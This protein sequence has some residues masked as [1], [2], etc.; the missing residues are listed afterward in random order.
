MVAS[1]DESGVFSEPAFSY[2][3][4]TAVYTAGEQQTGKNPDARSDIYSLGITLYQLTTGRLPEKKHEDEVFNCKKE[5]SVNGFLPII[6]KCMEEDP[7]NRYG[8]LWK[9]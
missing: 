6:K 7:K 8:L 9:V 2:A 4:G 5:K 1:S 3:F